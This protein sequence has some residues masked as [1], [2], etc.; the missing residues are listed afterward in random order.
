MAREKTPHNPSL[1]FTQHRPQLNPAIEEPP[2]EK[3]L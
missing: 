1:E 2:E 3:I